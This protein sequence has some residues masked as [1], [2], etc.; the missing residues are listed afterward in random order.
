M[1]VSAF[2][3]FIFPPKRLA[4]AKGYVVKAAILGRILLTV[5]LV[6]A[7]APIF[8]QR[9]QFP[10]PIDSTAPS[11][12]PSPTPQ[13]GYVQPGNPSAYPQPASP[14]LMPSGVPNYSQPN[15]ASVPPALGTPGTTPGTYTPAPAATAPP[16]MAPGAATQTPPPAWDPY[17]TPNGAPNTLLPQDPYFQSPSGAGVAT[18]QKFL[19]HIDL[20]YAW[21]A[22]NGSGE[23]GINDIQLTATFAFPMFFNSQT[24]ILVTPGFA[25]HYWQGPISV[26]PTPPATTPSPADM[27]PW[28][29]DAFL[30]VAWNPWVTEYL[31]AE[32]SFR[33][34]I[35]SDYYSVT[36][37]SL[38]FTGKGLAVVK[39][40]PHLTLKAGIWYL[41]RVNIKML[42]TGGLIWTPNADI[43][44]N[45]LF[46]DPKV[47]KR[48]T[49]WGNTEWWLYGRGEYGGGV[50]TVRRNP[51][52]YNNAVHDGVFYPSMSHDLVD[53]DDI[54][55]ALG[56]DFK[57]VRHL[58]GYFEV[59]LSC[60][61]ELNYKSGL[62]GAYYPNNTV[63]IGAGMS[64]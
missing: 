8:A 62:P 49:T 22:G 15:A 47:A 46:P 23:L 12:T 7:A 54:R 51:D 14:G 57:T 2:R 41:D 31:G 33:I 53:Y 1:K 28:T 32:L 13:P 60:S 16:L 63:F 5:L 20:D 9:Q 38:R 35:Y 26:L 36:S 61:R 43:Y 19:Q 6:F 59:G 52:I 56:L 50:W 4:I 44:F 3:L 21:F 40:S 24:P 18:M 48:L 42:P 17:A 64:Y 45:I 11:T 10:T 25:V 30:D 55:I 34:G 39:L 27:P 29:N 37:E 58:D